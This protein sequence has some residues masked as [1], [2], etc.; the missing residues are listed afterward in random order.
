MYTEF[1]E[2]FILFL[3]IDLDINE[4]NEK[5]GRCSHTCINLQG[6]YRCQCR[7]GYKLASDKKTCV[8]KYIVLSRKGFTLVHLSSIFIEAAFQ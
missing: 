4:C 6:S 8:G 2:T 3:L 5:K 7:A 1:R